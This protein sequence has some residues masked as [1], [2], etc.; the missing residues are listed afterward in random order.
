MGFVDNP[1]SEVYSGSDSTGATRNR[2]FQG[3]LPKSA[4]CLPYRLAGLRLPSLHCARA[5]SAVGP[6]GR[7]Q[8]FMS[9]TVMAK[10]IRI[11]R[12]SC[13]CCDTMLDG[14]EP[15]DGAPVFGAVPVTLTVCN[16][17]GH[18]MRVGRNLTLRELTNEQR[19]EAVNLPAVVAVR[20]QQVL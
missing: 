10:M 8:L 12:T 7:G 6:S 4:L 19:R 3:V 16:C 17:C 1:L 20:L 5:P 2:Q 13:P 18:L 9:E 11:E 14:I 15:I